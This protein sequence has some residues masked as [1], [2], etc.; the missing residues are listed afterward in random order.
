MTEFM[1]E[2]M[3]EL[4][5]A[6]CASRELADVVLSAPLVRNPQSFV[7]AFVFMEMVVDVDPPQITLPRTDANNTE[8]IIPTIAS[9]FS[10]C[11]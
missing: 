6:R 8:A 5:G 4:I 11:Q 1:Q 10:G 2:N 3:E 9:S 7:E